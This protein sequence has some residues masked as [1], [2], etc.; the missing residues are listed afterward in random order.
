MS[1]QANGLLSP[2]LRKKRI[3]IAVPYIKGRVLDYGCGVGVLAEFCKPDCYLGVD[4]DQESLTIARTRYPNFTFE[5]DVSDTEKFD[6]IIALAVIEH[7]AKP[8]DFLKKLQLMLK[9]EGQIIFSTPHPAFEWIHSL[10]AQVGLF[11]KEAHEE[12]QQLIDLKFM[13]QLAISLDLQVIEYHKFLM[14]ANQ[15]FVLK[16]VL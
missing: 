4:V 9:S 1:N 13:G 7:V 12:H 3:Q 16:H 2:W 10:G 8:Q 11:S 14:G 6:T 15:L 5:L